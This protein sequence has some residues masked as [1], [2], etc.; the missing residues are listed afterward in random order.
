MKKIYLMLSVLLLVLGTVFV[1]DAA[2]DRNLRSFFS[3]EKGEVFSLEVGDTEE[4][5]TKH[6]DITVELLEIAIN[7]EWV[8]DVSVDDIILSDENPDPGEEVHITIP[9][10]NIGTGT[11]H[12]VGFDIRFGDEEMGGD[13]GEFSAIPWILP[14]ETIEFEIDHTYEEEGSYTI[15]VS[16]LVSNDIDNSNNIECK[17][18]EVGNPPHGGGGCGAL[19]PN[20]IPKYAHIIYTENRKG[21]E[22]TQEELWVNPDSFGD[23]VEVLKMSL[24]EALMTVPM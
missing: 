12:G 17:I 4:I 21:N 10:S 5:V 1:V 18:F 8:S 24:T 16:A 23:L 15:M 7:P 11:A 3:T 13:H 14:G 20:D 19:G 6:G 9:I 22:V 2:T